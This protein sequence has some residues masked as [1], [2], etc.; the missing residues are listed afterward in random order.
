MVRVLKWVTFICNYAAVILLAQV[1]KTY[2]LCECWSVWLLLRKR[3]KGCRTRSAVQNSRFT[4]KNKI[5]KQ[6]LPFHI[7][8]TSSCCHSS[9]LLHRDAVYYAALVKF[10]VV[11]SQKGQFSASSLFGVT[12]A[13]ACFGHSSATKETFSP[14]GQQSNTLLQMLH[15]L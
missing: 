8:I 10:S 14:S 6:V 3:Q 4:K 15:H 2:S 1:D 7:L 11:L 5:F 9:G 12:L 13:L